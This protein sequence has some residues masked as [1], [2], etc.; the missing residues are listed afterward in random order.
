MTPKEKA[1]ELVKWATI[2]G[3]SSEVSKLFATKIIDEILKEYT[4]LQL[5]TFYCKEDYLLCTNMFEY[6]EKVKKNL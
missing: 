2:Y 4:I 3:A 5:N 6:W 1:E